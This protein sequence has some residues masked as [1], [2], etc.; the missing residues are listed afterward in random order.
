MEINT[1]MA[2]PSHFLKSAAGVR[3][4]GGGGGGGEGGGTVWPPLGA[5][6]VLD[7]RSSPAPAASRS[8]S[9]TA[10]PHPE[11]RTLDLGI[12]KSPMRA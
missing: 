6:I 5:G 10:A 12:R 8:V 9:C 7:M 3:C 4:R 11:A 1:Q 2:G